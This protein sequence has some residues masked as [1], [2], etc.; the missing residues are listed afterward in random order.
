MVVAA[1]QR[2]ICLEQ[3]QDREVIPAEQVRQRKDVWLRTHCHNGSIKKFVVGTNTALVG[4]S[5]TLQETTSSETGH[6][7]RY[8]GRD[9]MK[10][11]H[12]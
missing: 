4:L 10:K 7:G 1:V 5:K 3:K 8:K 9:P 6:R 11:I 12:Q 2:N